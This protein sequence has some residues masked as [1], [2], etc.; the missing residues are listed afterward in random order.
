MLP[1]TVRAEWLNEN[2]FSLKF[3]VI[4]FCIQ[5]NTENSKRKSFEWIS[6]I[7]IAE[8]TNAGKG[9]RICTLGSKLY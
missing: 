9:D 5:S 2:L 7:L 1:N 6:F 8:E 3:K 4:C